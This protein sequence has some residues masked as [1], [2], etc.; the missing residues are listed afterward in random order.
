MNRAILVYLSRAHSSHNF[1]FPHVGWKLLIQSCCGLSCSDPKPG[2]LG[3]NKASLKFNQQGL[4]TWKKGSAAEFF[5]ASL[6]VSFI[7]ISTRTSSYYQL[8]IFY[9]S[10]G[11]HQLCSA[12]LLWVRWNISHW[13][14]FLHEISHKWW[15]LA[16]SRIPGKTDQSCL[17]AS[18]HVWT[19]ISLCMSVKMSLKM[20]GGCSPM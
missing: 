10:S 8:S 17:L 13:A 1:H 15:L 7:V 6:F 2:S 11:A 3:T 9:S 16:G 4:S 14:Q 20:Q 19:Y 18:A 12:A 5:R